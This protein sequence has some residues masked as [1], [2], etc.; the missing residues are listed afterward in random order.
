M[1]SRSSLS[2]NCKHGTTMSRAGIRKEKRQRIYARDGFRCVY[3][4]SLDS[5]LTL[6]HL[7][8]KLR[9]RGITGAARERQHDCRNL[10]T[11]C[12]SCNS[13]RQAKSVR[14]FCLVVAARTGEHWADIWLR[15]KACRRRKLSERKS[16]P[17]NVDSSNPVA[18]PV[19]DREPA[20][21]ARGPR[22]FLHDE[23]S[24]A[25]M[26]E[27]MACALIHA[28]EFRASLDRG[29]VPLVA[30]SVESLRTSLRIT[31]GEPFRVAPLCSTRCWCA[32]KDP[33]CYPG[34]AVQVDLGAMDERTASKGDHALVVQDV[35]GSGRP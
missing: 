30:T 35:A 5:T 28:G 8:P 1:N 25:E 10:V 13:S 9:F 6:D 21:R 4:N 26:L 29:S 33:S 16:I 11:A 18:R 14:A 20:H 12:L 15:V 23:C 31:P 19:A 7:Q 22:L 27:A 2:M 34:G 24:G 32:S 17:P 3:C